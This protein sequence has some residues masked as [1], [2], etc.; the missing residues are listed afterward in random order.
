VDGALI[1]SMNEK[2]M[3]AALSL[4]KIHVNKFRVK[5]KR[6]QVCSLGFRQRN[7]VEVTKL[8][9]AQEI[10]SKDMEEEEIKL[11]NFLEDHALGHLFL[12]SAFHSDFP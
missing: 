6:L 4:P 12:K 1:A 3:E 9:T 11:K 10:F 7:G 2:E 5:L 8:S